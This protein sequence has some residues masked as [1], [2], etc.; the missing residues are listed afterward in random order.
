[1][2]GC[3]KA[4]IECPRGPTTG[5]PAAVGADRRRRRRIVSWG[6]EPATAANP[7]DVPVDARS[8]R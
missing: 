2:G 8:A 5:P 4:E 1:M 3:T 7:T 6:L